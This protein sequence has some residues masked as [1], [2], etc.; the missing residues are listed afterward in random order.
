LTKILSLIYEHRVV[1]KI[2]AHIGLLWGQEQNA[3][4]NHLQRNVWRQLLNISM[5]ADLNM[6]R[7]SLMYRHDN[8]LLQNN[9]ARFW[10]KR[11]WRPWS[12]ISYWFLVKIIAKVVLKG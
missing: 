5:M 9:I 11:S 7:F 4:H 12:I 6:R 2:L 1:K 10:R 3:D 8:H